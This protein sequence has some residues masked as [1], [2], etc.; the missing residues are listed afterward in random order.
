MKNYVRVSVCKSNVS[1]EKNTYYARVCNEGKINKDEL[2]K[3]VQAKIPYIDSIT[4]E[5]VAKA[6]AEVTVDCVEKGFSVDFLGLGTFNLS[7]KGSVKV[8]EP[9]TKNL[10]GIFKKKEDEMQEEDMEVFN[11]EITEITKGSVKFKMQFSPSKKVREHIKETVEASIVSVKKEKPVIRKVEKIYSSSLD[12][13]PSVIK[14]EGDNLKLLGDGIELY[15]KADNE[16]FQIP[17]E[18]VLRNEPKTLMFLVNAPLRS[19][20]EYTLGISTQYAKMGSRQTSIIRRGIK[21]FNLAKEE[22]AS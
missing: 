4:I 14:I 9:L 11:K 6:I 1:K 3:M 21:R 17:K 15:I 20:K 7:G 18:A 19:G 8:S 13:A 22:G 2:L 5:A 16:I 10:D 12:N